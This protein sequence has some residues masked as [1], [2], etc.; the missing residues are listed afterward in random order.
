MVPR[1]IQDTMGHLPFLQA[2]GA[3]A[4]VS[5][6][7]VEVYG[8]DVLNLLDDGSNVGAWQGVAARAVL[9]GRAR[10]ADAASSSAACLP[11]QIGWPPPLV[12]RLG[13]LGGMLR[14]PPCLR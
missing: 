1:I 9:D 4:A 10:Q 5:L 14:C 3:T 11:G 7:Y 2:R 6:S 8:N 12:T 13:V